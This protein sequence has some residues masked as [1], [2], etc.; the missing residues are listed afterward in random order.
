MAAAILTSRCQTVYY[1]HPR[2][3][4]WHDPE[5]VDAIEDIP[6]LPDGGYDTAAGQVRGHLLDI[7]LP[8]E[9][10]VRMSKVTPVYVDIHGGGFCYGYKE[11]NRNFNTHLAAQGFAVVSLNYRPAPQT[12]LKGQLADIQAAL[13]WLKAHLDDYPV[14]PNAVFVTGDSA[15]GALALLTLAIENGERPPRRSASSGHPAS[16]FAAVRW[17]AVYTAWPRRTRRP[18]AASGAERGSAKA[19]KPRL[20]RAS[21]PG[22]RPPIR[23]S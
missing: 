12:D 11:L 21:S 7:Y 10:A 15:G 5:G 9:A 23:T 2:I 14:D 1:D 4:R 8:H 16:G 6:Y 13:C 22:W 17:C 20:V 19:S 3:E 18:A